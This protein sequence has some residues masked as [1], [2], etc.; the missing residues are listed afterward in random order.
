[1]TSTGINERYKHNVV[2][3]SDF[4][5][6]L[7]AIKTGSFPVDEALVTGIKTSRGG[8]VF[9]RGFVTTVNCNPVCLLATVETRSSAVAERPRDASCH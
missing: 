4:L 3:F 1:V 7:S 8:I 2:I 5:S 6:S 9:G